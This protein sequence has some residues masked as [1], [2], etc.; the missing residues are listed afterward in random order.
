MGKRYGEE[1][2][3]KSDAQIA[4]VVILGELGGGRKGKMPHSITYEAPDFIKFKSP[5]LKRLRKELEAHSFDINRKNGKPVNP[6]WLKNTVI[7]LGEAQF[8]VGL[9]GLHSMEKS[10]TVV[11][12]RSSVMRNAD[13]ASFYPRII[14]NSKLFPPQLG[15]RF[16]DVYEGIVA[17]RLKAK[18]EGDKGTAETLKIVINGS[19]GK[20]GSMYSKLYAPELMLAVTFTGQLALLMLI[21]GL[22][23]NGVPVISANTDGVEYYCPRKS[24]KK[25]LKIIRKWEK[26]T[27]YTM[28]NDEYISLHARDVNNYI[29]KYDGYVKS[30]GVYK[31]LDDQPI[32]KK[33][34]QYPICFKA[35]RDYLEYDKPIKET[36]DE[37]KDVSQ[38]TSS[39]VVRGGATWNGEKIGKTVRWYHNNSGLAMHYVKP[40][41]TG[42]H[43]KVP[44]TDNCRP[45]MDLPK[46]IPKDLDLEWY[47]AYAHRMLKELG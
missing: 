36:I 37:C 25:A 8:Q 47:I 12:D 11:S 14:I 30:K 2:R 42:N 18:A 31:D 43:N 26:L 9:G 1:L 34:P 10:I 16:L 44:L 15:E 38:F 27:G 19:F 3:S 21:E 22:E 5:E 20:F 40:N 41:T 32:L 28:E 17:T 29:A 4:E 39:R 45:M 6:D 7:R 24:V 46:K 33:S 23:L 35:V 13:V